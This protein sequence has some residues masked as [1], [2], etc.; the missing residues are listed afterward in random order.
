MTDFAAITGKVVVITGGARGIGLA[1]ATAL[2]ALGAKIAIGDIDETTVKE[3]GTARGFEV[4]G[5]LDVTDHQS[6][7]AFLDDV[8]RRLGPIDVLINNAGI[9]PT[10]R[11]VDEPDQ[12]TRR[13]L[14][15]NVYGVILGSKLAIARMLPR[16]RGQVINIASL[17]GETHIPG[18]A[19]YNASK[20]AVLGF[21]D[22]LREEYRGTGL[23]FSAVL[24]TLTKTELGSGVTPPKLL[25]PAEPEEIADAIAKLIVEPRSKVRVTTVAGIISQVVGFLPQA[26]GDAIGRALGA[27]SAFLDDVDSDARKAYEHRVRE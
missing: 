23:S 1:T 10:G 21:T 13:I 16:G 25:R 3:S 6:F 27:Q 20:H 11:V 5:K 22:T 24:P 26:V 8:E 2:Q 4:F 19:T 7:E 17:A 15:I 12:I 9:M 18:L 14:D